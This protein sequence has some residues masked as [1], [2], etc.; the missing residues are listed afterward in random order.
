MGVKSFISM[1]SEGFYCA[2]ADVYIDTW[3]SVDFAIITH[4][5]SDHARGGMKH[6]LAHKD[7]EEVLRLRLG[8]G[9]SLQTVEYGESVWKNGVE[10]TLFPAGHVPG[11]AQVRLRKGKDCWVIT[12]DYKTVGDG[13]T[14][15]FEPVECD[16]IITEST[17]G[18]PV[19]RWLPQEL[20]FN[21]VNAWWR[22]C[23]EAGEYAVLSTYS[24]GK[25]QRVMKYLDRGIGEVFCHSAVVETNLALERQGFEFGEWMALP[26]AGGRGKKLGLLKELI[27]SGSLIVCPP[28]ALE[29]NLIMSLGEYQTGSCSGWMQLRGQRRWGNLDRGFVL[30][31]HA[32]WQ[33]LN[34]AVSWS[35]AE[36]I[37]VTHG[38]SEIFARYL[39]EEKGLNACTVSVLRG[40]DFRDE[41]LEKGED[42]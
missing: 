39:R 30:S 20:V 27:P 36:N 38:Y 42:G 40:E 19:Y 8:K 23:L 6:Y 10:I 37:Y 13:L 4:A 26:T 24:L 34:D 31:D 18:L 16:S 12:G 21:E 5:H 29:S 7:S 2:E 32:D 35:G 41:V 1:R 11:S 14:V 25:A 22:G 15:A 33:Q 28:A 3:R 17:F 9:I